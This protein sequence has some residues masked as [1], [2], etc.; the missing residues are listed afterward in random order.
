L[1]EIFKVNLKI[2]KFNKK[3][4]TEALQKAIDV[5]VR[6][7]AREWLRAVIHEVPVYSGQARASLLPLSRY[8]R[9]ALPIEPTEAGQKRYPGGITKGSV[10]G[11][12]DFSSEGYV[13][14]FS[15]STTV[16]HF[17]I[18]EFNVGL[19]QPP[20]IHPTPWKSM[21]YGKIA[22]QAYL[23]ENLKKKLPRIGKYVT[24]VKVSENG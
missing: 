17:L 20:L 23:R 15:F 10:Q 1:A 9:V 2:L 24:L 21:E 7:A 22:F 8:L 3:G 12:F 5:Q 6:Q 18:N 19:G 16:P 14:R 11:Q 13:S 4:Y